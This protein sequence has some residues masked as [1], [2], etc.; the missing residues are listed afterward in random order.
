MDKAA[1]DAP[2]SHETNR[3]A[4]IEHGRR[5]SRIRGNRRLI[6]VLR[7][8]SSHVRPI[9]RSESFGVIFIALTRNSPLFRILLREIAAAIRLRCDKYGILNYARCLRDKQQHA[10]AYLRVHVTPHVLLAKHPKDVRLRIDTADRSG[11]CGGATDLPECFPK[12]HA[13]RVSMTRL[14]RFAFSSC[15]NTYL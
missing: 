13:A 3:C 8:Q 1:A 10:C 14:T 12:I 4:L 2:G 11:A 5:D 9:I 6:G 7:A 15:E